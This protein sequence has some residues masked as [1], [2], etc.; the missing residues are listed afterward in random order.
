MSAAAFTLG[1]AYLT[2]PEVYFAHANYL[3]HFQFRLL[4]K[5]SIINMLLAQRLVEL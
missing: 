1:Q 4:S 2:G 3:P 5:F